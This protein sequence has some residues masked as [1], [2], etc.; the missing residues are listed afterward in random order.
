M[1]LSHAPTC[2]AVTAKLLFYHLNPPLIMPPSPT[3]LP[4]IITPTLLS[5][6]RS[7]PSLPPQSWYYISAVALSAINRP[8]E[9]GAVFR[10]AVD[11]IG[12][13]RIGNNGSREEDG[14]VRK[15]EREEQM[16]VARRMREA[17]IKGGVVCGLPKV[18]AHPSPSTNQGWRS[19]KS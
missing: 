5:Y 15:R 7:H 17:L 11:R 1:K 10:D 9:I 13:E 16:K 18:S 2:T 3:S 8:D 12:G 14:T 4:K 6:L 19:K